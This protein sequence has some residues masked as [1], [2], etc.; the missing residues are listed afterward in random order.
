MMRQ[1]SAKVGRCP[2]SC[3]GGRVTGAPRFA[4]GGIKKHGCSRKNS[5]ALSKTK[6]S[7]M[8]L[9]HPWWRHVF[10]ASVSTLLWACSSRAQSVQFQ[11]SN[12]NSSSATLTGRFTPTVYVPAMSRLLVTLAGVHVF[13]GDAISIQAR[14]SVPD[15]TSG[16]KMRVEK[17]SGIGES[18]DF[19]SAL[20]NNNNFKS[21]NPTS[22]SWTSEM[23]Y[24]QSDPQ[25]EYFGRR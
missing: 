2:L 5:R 12:I 13:P 17:F 1:A 8:H 16:Q 11:L 24:T 18:G 6:F 21:N 4:N 20:V 25:E 7:A 3:S 23:R 19:I 15:Q 9:I 14:V 22:R 10:F